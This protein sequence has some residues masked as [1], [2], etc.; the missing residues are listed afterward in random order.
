MNYTPEQISEIV[1]KVLKEVNTPNLSLKGKIELAIN[2]NTPVETLKVLATDEN[3]TVR[4]GVATNPNTSVEI[5]KVLATDKDW[6]VRCVV[7]QH[8]N[9]SVETLKV[10]A[11][12]KNSAVRY[13]V[14]KNPNYNL[15]DE[16]NTSNLSYQEKIELAD[17]PNTP[18]ETLKVLSTDKQWNV[19]CGVALNPNT[20]V[21]TLKV[22]ATDKNS[23]VRY[24]VAA[25]PNYKVINEVNTLNLSY[26]EKLELAINPNTS[27]ETLK[28]LAT[29]WNSTV[30]YY[31]AA[32]QNYKIK[33][34]E[35]T[36]IQYDALN[37]LLKSS[38][39][40]AL[41]NLTL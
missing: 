34:L 37:T 11:T 23:T 29:D 18:V 40:E 12:D 28:V 9:T 35:L 15:L 6:D 27:A 25:N 41:K 10:L 30:R 31:V 39:V 26:Q 36:S 32:N 14:A 33:N 22:L 5:L 17:N 38:Q 7:A 8:P 3:S 24:Y 1:L 21:E 20:P 16:V 4:Y 2:P 19:R 13:Y